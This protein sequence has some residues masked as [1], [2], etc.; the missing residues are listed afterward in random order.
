[1]LLFSL[2]GIHF[3]LISQG[4]LLSIFVTDSYSKP[5]FLL[6][7]KLAK[8]DVSDLNYRLVKIEWW[9]IPIRVIQIVI[10][11]S[12]A[13]LGLLFLITRGFL[14]QKLIFQFTR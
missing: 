12:P 5:G 4:V 10:F 6:L 3:S 2:F 13:L 11:A 9:Q 1:M 8:L 14:E 7:A